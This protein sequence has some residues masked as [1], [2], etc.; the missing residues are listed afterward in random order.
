[1]YQTTSANTIAFSTGGEQ[2]VTIIPSTGAIPAGMINGLNVGDG[3]APVPPAVVPGIRRLSVIAANSWEDGN[4]GN[5]SALVFTPIDFRNVGPVVVRP[6]S[7]YNVAPGAITNVVSG[8]C[9]AAV[10]TIIATKLLPKGFIVPTVS[11]GAIV[12]SSAINGAGLAGGAVRINLT[13][14]TGATIPTGQA[15]GSLSPITFVA[16]SAQSQLNTTAT[17]PVSNGL[18]YVAVSIT[19]TS[20]GLVAAAGLLGVSVPIERA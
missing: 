19:T 6:F 17:T 3:I 5:S 2:K 18:Q 14:I 10:N 9:S 13:A 1:M 7:S 15:I 20:A 4:C 8:Q 11:L 16:G 12:Y